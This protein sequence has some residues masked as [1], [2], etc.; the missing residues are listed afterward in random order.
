VEKGSRDPQREKVGKVAVD[1][2]C[3]I[4]TENMPDLNCTTIKSAMRITAGTAVDIGIDVNPPIL[5][6]KV[7]QLL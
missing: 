1:Q 7:K 4:A 5:E 2:L 6:K 3:T